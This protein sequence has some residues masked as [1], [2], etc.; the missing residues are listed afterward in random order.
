MEVLDNFMRGDIREEILASVEVVY[1]YT[2]LASYNGTLYFTANKIYWLCA[3]YERIILSSWC[4]NANEIA[5][6]KKK[7]LAGYT[8]TLKDGKSIS[9]SNIF[10]KKREAL[11]AALQKLV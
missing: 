10:R 5:T 6:Y 2:K 7:G 4:I 9:L 3:E 11:T 1:N 8:I